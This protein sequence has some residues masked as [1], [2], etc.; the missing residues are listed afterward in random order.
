MW[1]CN[2]KVSGGAGMTNAISVKER[3]KKQAIEDGKTMQDKLVTYGLERTI[4]RLSVS[5]YKEAMPNP[6]GLLSAAASFDVKCLAVSAIYM[7]VD[8]YANYKSYN[9]GLYG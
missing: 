6:V 8:S 2:E 5:K 4:Y 7:A 9:R 1:R 3:L